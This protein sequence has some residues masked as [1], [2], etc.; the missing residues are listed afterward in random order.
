MAADREHRQEEVTLR[1]THQEERRDAIK[2][3]PSQPIEY[4]R[5]GAPIEIGNK[6]REINAARIVARYRFARGRNMSRFN[7]AF[8][9][10]LS[11]DVRAQQ[12]FSGLFQRTI[13]DEN[14]S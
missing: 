6:Y 14:V 11:A 10:C 8:A 9:R 5:T 12:T 2:G 13:G 7:A 4:L 3:L 1:L